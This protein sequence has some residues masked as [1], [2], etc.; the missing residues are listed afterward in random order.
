MYRSPI[1]VRVMKSRRLIW[2]GHVTTMGEGRSAFKILK[3]TPAGNR[4]LGRP[5]RRWEDHIRILKKWV[6]I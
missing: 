3:G 6:S 1:K 5:K 4:P 2:T